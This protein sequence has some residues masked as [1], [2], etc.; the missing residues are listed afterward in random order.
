M[1]KTMYVLRDDMTGHH[2]DPV[3]HYEESEPK[4]SLIQALSDNNPRN[5]LRLFASHITLMRVADFDTETGEVTAYQPEFV[6]TLNSLVVQSNKVSESQ[7]QDIFDDKDDVIDQ[8]RNRAP[9]SNKKGESH[10]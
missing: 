2:L 9:V 10:E 8:M 6:C 3:L 4:R 5:Q 7:T 1:I